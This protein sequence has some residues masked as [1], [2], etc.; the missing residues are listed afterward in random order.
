M[1]R[2]V[3][4]D[5]DGT[6]IRS[7]DGYIAFN[8]AIRKTFGVEGD[9]RAVIPDGNTDPL[10]VKD[11]L[12]QLAMD[13]KISEN[14]WCDFSATLRECYD[15]H[16]CRGTMRIQSLPGA[17]ELLAA[18]SADRRF[19]STVV[20]GNFESTAEVKLMA[21]GLARYLCR[22]A[23]ASDSSH[24]PD[25]PAI[26]RRRCEELNRSS[27]SNE[28]CVIVGDTPKDLD[29]ARQ[30][31]MKCILVGTGRYPV[32]ELLHWQPDG[33]VADLSDTEAMI[34]LLSEI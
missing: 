32:E 5:I 7:R 20:T 24:R 33:C 13:V 19:V 34:A 2:L 10:I 22:G 17:V 12:G 31:G 3:L 21:A 16:L 6:L 26:A 27:F 25:L 15:D 30:S 9:I 14:Q 1:E 8:E 4:F 29:A 11:I 23:Y 28:R 18:L